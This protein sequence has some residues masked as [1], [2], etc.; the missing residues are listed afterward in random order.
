M[1]ISLKPVKLTDNFSRFTLGKPMVLPMGTFNSLISNI[2]EIISKSEAR[3]GLIGDLPY[4]VSDRNI[5]RFTCKELNKFFTDDVINY[6]NIGLV[7][8]WMT[9]SENFAATYY[10]N[11]FS[12][13]VNIIRIADFDG[14]FIN[15]DAV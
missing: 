14:G 15:I 2:T 7:D 13:F 9:P 6:I 1:L 5:D 4:M 11:L 8:M 12:E 10:V 3:M